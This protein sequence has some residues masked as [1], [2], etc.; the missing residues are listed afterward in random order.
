MKRPGTRPADSLRTLLNL[1]VR[2]RLKM[3]SEIDQAEKRVADLRHD[4]KL[5]ADLEKR[6]R[7]EIE[8]LEG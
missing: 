8:E 4:H 1:T 6:I 5:I 3:E 7:N 2:G